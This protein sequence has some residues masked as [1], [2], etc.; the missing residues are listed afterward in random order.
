MDHGVYSFARVCECDIY[1]IACY[2]NL[3]RTVPSHLSVHFCWWSF[4]YVDSVYYCFTEWAKTYCVSCNYSRP[5]SAPCADL[6]LFYIVIKQWRRND[7]HCGGEA[8]PEGQKLEA[9]RA[10]PGWGSWGG[11]VSPEAD[12]GIFSMFGRTGAPTK[13]GP[14]HEDQKK[15]CNLPESHWTV[16]G[17]SRPIIVL[18]ALGPHIF[19]NRARFRV[20]PALGKPPPHQLGDLG[21]AVSSPS[22]VRGGRQEVWCILDSVIRPGSHSLQLL[23][24]GS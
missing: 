1:F 10:E 17:S 9:R 14:P 11:A 3:L 2:M 23:W 21:S 22:G 19:L 24:L 8:R 20:N 13:M 16:G 12:L 4:L 6:S 15:F 5:F 7:Q 18:G